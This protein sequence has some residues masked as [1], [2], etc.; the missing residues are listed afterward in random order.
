MA[1]SF[2]PLTGEPQ[3]SWGSMI[4]VINGRKFGVARLNT[5]VMQE[6]RS[7]V[8]SIRS[9]IHHVPANVGEWEAE[10][11]LP[12]GHCPSPARILQNMLD[13]GGGR[14]CTL[15][16]AQGLMTR[17]CLTT[18]QSWVQAKVDSGA[19]N[20]LS[21]SQPPPKQSNCIYS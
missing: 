2:F 9:S 19:G 4:G 7:G 8:S 20:F 12:L 11:R 10:H 5:S 18:S 17:A 3:G 1:L 16:L 14:A 6:V 13:L 15:R 21:P